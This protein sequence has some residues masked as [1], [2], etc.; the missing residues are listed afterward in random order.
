MTGGTEPALTTTEDMSAEEAE[1]RVRGL[2]RRLRG[3][4]HFRSLPALDR[5]ADSSPEERPR[6]WRRPRPP[7]RATDG[8]KAISLVRRPV[9][10]FPAELSVASIHARLRARLAALRDCLEEPLRGDL[11][12]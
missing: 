11:Y 7:D 2:Y 5:A 4:D 12:K 9:P 3:A 8:V 1:Q 6:G 10:H